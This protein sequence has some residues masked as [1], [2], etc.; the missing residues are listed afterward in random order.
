MMVE[1]HG[2]VGLKV[3]VFK[4]SWFDTTENRSMRIH[5]S[6][7]VDVSPRRQYAKYDPFVLPGNCDQ[8]CFISYP[9]DDRRDQVAESSLL[10]LETHVVDDVSDYDISPGFI[11]RFSSFFS[12]LREKRRNSRLATQHRITFSDSSLAVS[13]SKSRHLPSPAFRLNLTPLKMNS[14]RVHGTHV[15]SPPMPPG[16]TGPVFNHAGSPPMPPGATGPAFNHPGSPP[17]PP[18]ATGPAL[19]HTA[20]SSRSNSYPQMTLNAMLNSPARLLQ[21]HLHPD[22]LNGALWILHGSLEELKEGSR[23]KEGF[24]EANICG[25]CLQNFYWES[26]FDDLVYGLWKKETWTTIAKKKSKK[27]ATSRKSDP[28]GKS[29]HK[30]NAGPRSFARIAYNMKQAS[31]TGE[32]PSYTALVRETHSRP[33]GTFED[34]RAE[35]Q[36]TQAEME[37]TQLSNTEGSPGSPSASSAPSRLMLNK[38]YLKS[39]RGYVYGLGSEQYREH[40]PSTRIPNGLARNLELEMRVGGLETSLQRVTADVAGVKQDVAGVK[41]DVSDMRQDFSSTREAI[42]QLLQTLRPPQAPTGQT[43]DQP[44]A[45][46]AQPNPPNGI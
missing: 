46:T 41:Q 14:T 43:S 45:P 21:P 10:R 6:G 12:T 36:V 2:D 11:L 44:Q 33:D 29:C 23:G 24:M 22:K 18:G 15:V 28:V 4:C 1:Y 16:A 27:A 3:I 34:Y 5:S 32:P 42:N 7:L 25:H 13:D 37:A 30:H 39:K 17:M 26:Q 35:E 31:A 8:A 40:A 19:N 9:R 38:A 20:S